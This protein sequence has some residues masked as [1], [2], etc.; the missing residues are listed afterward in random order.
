MNK[1]TTSELL[2]K[3][4]SANNGKWSYNG[5]PCVLD[6]YADWCMPCKQQEVVLKDMIK[7]YSDVVFYKINI[8]E[9]YELAEMFSIKSLPTI[10]ICGKETKQFTG[11]IPK[12][13][14]E[15]FLKPQI[16]ILV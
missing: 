13:K 3:G 16:D 4:F 1:V 2:S 11:F 8:E 6:F 15:S 9:E 5:K 14:I 7:D 12:Q 10:I